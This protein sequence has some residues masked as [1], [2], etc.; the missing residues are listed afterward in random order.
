[1]GFSLLSGSAP[2]DW[3]LD[4]SVDAQS[5]ESLADF[6]SDLGLFV[7]EHLRELIA[8]HAALIAVDDCAILLPGASMSGKST[9]AKA[10]VDHG[11]LVA[12]DEYA[13]IDPS[14][15]L[16]HS[17]A[18]P[19]RM[20]TVGGWQ[21]IDAARKV[22]ALRVCLVADLEYQDSVAASLDTTALTGGELVMRL[23]ANTV[24]ARTRPE[25]SLNAA[26]AVAHQ[27]V[28]IQGRR[29]D[30]ALAMTQ[31]AELARA[32]SSAS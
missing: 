29:G 19:I 11:L 16:A 9:L 5:D 25:A 3:A 13:L 22:A 8:I 26:T 28:G 20:R 6:E 31:L 10:A 12:G 7:A 1:M 14:T 24:C 4:L 2:S 15:G 17:W 30:A 23:L 32:Q 27:A 21:R 18:R